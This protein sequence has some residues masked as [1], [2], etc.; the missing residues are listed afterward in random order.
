LGHCSETSARL[1]GKALGYDIVGTFDTSEAC[2]IGKARQKN[3]DKDL[4][5]GIVIAGERLYVDISSIHEMSFGG[6]KSWA[7]IVVDNSGYF[8][9]YFMKHK[10]E[11]K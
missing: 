9:S 5:G 2:S 6:S 8:W 1:T 4:T 3:V 10:S 7:L 11:L